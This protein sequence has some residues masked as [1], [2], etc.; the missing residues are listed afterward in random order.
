MQGYEIADLDRLFRMRLNRLNRLILIEA[1]K[2][3]G[4]WTPIL[5]RSP[6]APPITDNVQVFHSAYLLRDRGLL[7]LEKRK[8]NG[9]VTACMRLTPV[10]IDIAK[11]MAGK[12][13]FGERA[14][15]SRSVKL[16]KK[17][18]KTREA[19]AAMAAEALNNPAGAC[20]AGA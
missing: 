15:I 8:F 17:R 19:R 13:L 3:G 4:A 6:G 9:R 12:L 14:Y 18:I 5:T 10:G 1:V 11:T 16:L 7:Q 2:V 20:S